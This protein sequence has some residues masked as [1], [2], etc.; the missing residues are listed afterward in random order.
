[1][2]PI[3]HSIAACSLPIF[4]FSSFAAE[5][6]PYE[7]NAGAKWME[8]AIEYEQCLQSK[9]ESLDDGISDAGTIGSEIW[10]ECRP[11]AVRYASAYT[12]F[13]GVS[14]GEKVAI[15]W[16]VLTRGQG[17]GAHRVMKNRMARNN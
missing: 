11:A 13:P 7:N 5:P 3:Y 17:I 4:C 14:F 6:L 9:A 12:A 1:M 16:T 15:W 10:S 2:N 8:T